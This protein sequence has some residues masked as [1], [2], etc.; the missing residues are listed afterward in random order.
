MLHDGVRIGT[1]GFGFAMHPEGHLDVPQL[2]R[3]VIEDSVEIGANSTVDRGAGPDTVIGQ[4][5]KIDNLVQIGHNV[6][7]GRGCVLVAQSGVA[8]SSEL[9]DFVV[10]AAQGGIAGHLTIGK[11][12]QV[13]AQ[14]GVMRDVPAGLAVLGSPA[15][16]AKQFFRL[17]SAWR[18]LVKSKGT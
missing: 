17:V 12:A 13:G 5:S 14:S 7:V 16:P 10:V 2:G 6:R 1:R 9:E 8:G 18:R 4:G 3:V 15:M 11:G